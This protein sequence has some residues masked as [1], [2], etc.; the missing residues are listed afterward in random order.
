MFCTIY[1][2]HR[3]KGSKQYVRWAAALPCL[4]QVQAGSLSLSQ[5]KKIAQDHVK[6]SGGDIFVRS[7]W[8]SRARSAN[9]LGAEPP[10]TWSSFLLVFRSCGS[11]SA[12]ACSLF[13]FDSSVTADV[14]K[15]FGR[16]RRAGKRRRRSSSSTGFVLHSGGEFLTLVWYVYSGKNWWVSKVYLFRPIFIVIFFKIGNAK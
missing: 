4:Q 11:D 5:E 15:L 12:C 16:R 1:S 6:A 3:F 13:D 2:G 14:A 8:P 10:G 7:D 9:S